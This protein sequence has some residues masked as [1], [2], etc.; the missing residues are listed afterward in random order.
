M[1][2]KKYVIMRYYRRLGSNITLAETAEQ[3]DDAFRSLIP[4]KKNKI[5][6]RVRDMIDYIETLGYEIQRCRKHY[7]MF[8]NNRDIIENLI[9]R[10]NDLIDE[11]ESIENE[12]ES[13]K[14]KRNRKFILVKQRFNWL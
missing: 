3:I 12:D 4:T 9:I 2:F 13:G 5:K 11:L 10:Q 1:L 6:N 7:L 8:R 14:V